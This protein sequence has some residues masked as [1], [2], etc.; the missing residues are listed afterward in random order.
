MA[1]ELLTNGNPEPMSIEGRL[2]SEAIP[3][4]RNLQQ[5]NVPSSLGGPYVDSPLNTAES[6][7]KQDANTDVNETEIIDAQI[8]A[9]LFQRIQ[10]GDNYAKFELGQFYFE[11]REYTDAKKLFD[12]ISNENMQAIYQLAVMYY[13]GLGVETN[14]KRAVEMMKTVIGTQ[15]PQWEFLVPYAQYQLGRAFFE[16]FGVEQSDSEAEMLWIKAA[17]DGDPDGSVKAQT[18]LGMFYS[19]PGEDTYDIQKAHFWHQE[20]T[21][22]GS[23]ESQAALGLLY[24][25]GLGVI[26]DNKASYKCLKSAAERGNIYAIGNMS[27]Y[28]YKLKLF[29]NAVDFAQRAISI[30]DAE[31]VA[32]VT[33]C[34]VHYIRKGIA[35]SCFVYGRCLAKGYGIYRDQQTALKYYAKAA[36]FDLDIASHLQELMIQGYI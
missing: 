1:T 19:R 15:D 6:I 31:K 29:N 34:L 22:N 26:K 35:M 4:N 28:Y 17:R 3:L 5:E 12:E 25:H 36:E 2:S 8:I 23:L 10:A 24:Q 21:G 18:T 30:T 14:Y 20:A 7:P 33:G 32:E 27:Y 13:D 9:D 16:G 11:R